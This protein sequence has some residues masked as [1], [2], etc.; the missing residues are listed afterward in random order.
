MLAKVV[1]G[2]E[3]HFARRG[4]AALATLRVPHGEVLLVAV[5][6]KFNPLLRGLSAERRERGMDVDLV[7]VVV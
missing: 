5:Q 1:A 3:D 6:E 7:F 2:L 4:R